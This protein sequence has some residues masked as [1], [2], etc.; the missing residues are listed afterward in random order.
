VRRG[1]ISGV[2]SGL[3]L[4]ATLLLVMQPAGATHLRPK[5]AQSLNVSLVPAYTQCVAPDRN[6]GPPLAF[7]SCSSPQQVSSRLTVGNPPAQP[8]GLEGRWTIIAKWGVPGPPDDSGAPILTSIDDVRCGSSPSPGCPTPGADYAG[9]IDV[10]AVV[11][12]SDHYNAL[13]PGSTFPDP[14]TVQDLELSFPLSC[15]ATSDPDIGATCSLHS[16]ILYHY[17]GVA[18]D[19]KR[20]VLEFGQVRVMDGGEDGDAATDDGA[21]TFLTQGVFIP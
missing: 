3:A 11:R 12:I 8:A 14:A 1:V 2:G 9:D 7:P 5:I 16:D 15:A 10:R 13:A 6:H 21:E 17:P 18:K 20:M 19:S 4:V